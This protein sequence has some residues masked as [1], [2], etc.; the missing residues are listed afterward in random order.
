MSL[1]LVQI[2]D[3]GF[4]S[5]LG[6]PTASD[7]ETIEAD[8]A[9]LGI[10][11]GVPYDMRGTVSGASEGPLAVRKRSARFGRFLEHY[12]FDLGGEFLAGRPARVVDC[13][14]V[15]ADPRDIT[16]NAGRAVAAVRAIVH[17]GAVPI[18]LGGDDSIP[19]LV[20]RG[21][22]G[23]GPIHVLQIDAHIDFR[24][25]VEGIREGYSSPMRRA[26]EMPWV[27]R[28]VHV[29]ARGVGSA[30]PSDVADTLKRGNALITAREVRDRG[31]ERVIQEFPE[32]ANFYIAIDCDGLDPSVMPGTSAPMPGGLS[33]R[34]AADLIQG[35]VRRGNV[36]G[37]DIAE[38]FPSLDL[39]GI[40][41]LAIIRLI[42]ILIGTMARKMSG[43]PQR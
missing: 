3:P 23:R 40:T 21:L 7:L 32:G 28:I 11:Y 24:D 34:E 39:Q 35:V 30:R 41:A 33:F 12:D 27:E 6:F 14:D 43:E 15:P 37:M 5:F 17:R 19:A 25:E 9:I 26:S 42:T 16:G 22:D 29:G 1:P 8:F 10:P 13:G 4:T 18:V 36:I 20:L 31:V 2:S 38:F